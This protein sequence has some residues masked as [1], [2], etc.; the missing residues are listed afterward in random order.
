[1]SSRLVEG[2][3][4]SLFEI[5]ERREYLASLIEAALNEQPERCILVFKLNI[6]GAVKN[7]KLIKELAEL[8]E[9]VIRERFA[10]S[11]ICLE[12]LFLDNNLKTGP[13]YLLSLKG[14]P[15]HL[16][17]IALAIEEEHPLGRLFDLD[18]ISLN[19][20]ISRQDLTYPGRRCFCCEQDAKICGR[21]RAHSLSDLLLAVENILR[22]AGLDC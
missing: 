2:V 16:K 5:L 3:E 8:A 4:A 9:Q 15:F 20:Q 17:S 1:M 22:K 11:G 12:E 14:E 18:I 13:E 19:G 21:S 10:Q 7:N 6:P